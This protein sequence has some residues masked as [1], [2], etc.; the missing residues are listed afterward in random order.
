MK[1]SDVKSNVNNLW[2]E[3]A[4][5]WKDDIAQK[6]KKVSIDEIDELLSSMQKLSNQ[7]H[8]DADE[9]LDLLQKIQ[10]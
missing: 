6:F 10:R 3:A 8:F 1:F 5:S 4:S 9:T 2:D 7:L